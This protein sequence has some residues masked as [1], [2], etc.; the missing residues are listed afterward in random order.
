MAYKNW[1]VEKLSKILKQSSI[2]CHCTDL[3][4]LTR[5]GMFSY[6]FYPE[7]GN[8][9]PLLLT[10]RKLLM[11]PVVPVERLYY[12]VVEIYFSVSEASKKLL[13]SANIQQFICNLSKIFFRIPC[14]L[15]YYI[16]RRLKTVVLQ[17]MRS[18]GGRRILSE[19]KS[20][21]VWQSFFRSLGFCPCMLT[22]SYT[23]I[24][25]STVKLD[26]K[27]LSYSL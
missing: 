7:R 2:R 5:C 21:A 19:V 11:L 20:R 1:K 8:E 17:L 22:D 16:R 27:R 4:L 25:E 6:S 12:L 15:L 10:K 3:R 26:V 14:T 18:S 13:I 23:F 24:E 9:I